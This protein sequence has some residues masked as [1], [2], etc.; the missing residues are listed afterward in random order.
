[1]PYTTVVGRGGYFVV[2]T[3]TGKRLNKKPHSSKSKAKRHIAALNANKNGDTFE[4][5]FKVLRCE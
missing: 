1:M 5:W 4:K 2:N 3:N